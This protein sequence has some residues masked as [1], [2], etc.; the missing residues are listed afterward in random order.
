MFGSRTNARRRVTRSHAVSQPVQALEQ[1]VVLSGGLLGGVAKPVNAQAAQQAAAAIQ[2]KWPSP[3]EQSRLGGAPTSLATDPRTAGVPRNGAT[4]EKVPESSIGSPVQTPDPFGLLPQGN[5]QTTGNDQFDPARFGLPGTDFGSDAAFLKRLEGLIPRNQHRQGGDAGAFAGTV[6]TDPATLLNQAGASLKADQSSSDG[7]GT[8]K[9]VSEDGNRVTVIRRD[10]NGVE[11][12][13][14]ETVFDPGTNT[15]TTTESHRT[16]GQLDSWTQTTRG[17]DGNKDT[18]WMRRD[19][20]G[21]WI[22]NFGIL[23]TGTPRR[24]GGTSGCPDPDGSTGGGSSGW[25]PGKAP[26]SPWDKAQSTGGGAGPGAR[27]DESATGNVVPRLNVEVNLT[28][29][30]NPYEGT[31]SGSPGHTGYNPNDFRCPPRPTN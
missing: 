17:P 19:S 22:S 8:V 6:V 10:D 28:G 2:V 12:S 13:R 3:A 31:P 21:S 30:P 24:Q 1:R 11:T 9:I 27:P 4:I 14:T 29:Q 26:A 18:F 16:N 7:N 20:S 15:T 23:G 25:L 5:S